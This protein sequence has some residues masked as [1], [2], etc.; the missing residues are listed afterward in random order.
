MKSIK[1]SKKSRNMLAA[2]L[3]GA[4]AITGMSIPGAQAGVEVGTLICS[5]DSGFG[6]I[7]GSSKGLECTFNRADGSSEE[8]DGRFT[9]V[10]ADIGWT[11]D[12][13]LA[14]IVFAPSTN[15]DFGGLRGSYVGVTAEA[16]AIAGIGANYLV[17]SFSKAIN[18][19]PL[20]FNGQLGLNAAAGLGS[21]RL[22]PA[23]PAQQQ[24]FAK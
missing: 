5:R 6:F 23:R 15:V 2:A 19:Q 7:I 10:G 8:Y 12:G 16:T 21:L 13:G 22:T 17:G 3:L 18:L 20:S 11:G 9:K 14:W 24:S 4:V 1:T